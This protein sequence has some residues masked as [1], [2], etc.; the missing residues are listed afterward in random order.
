M[1]EL[2]L[3]IRSLGVEDRYLN[4]QSRLSIGSTAQEKQHCTEETKGEAIMEQFLASKHAQKTSFSSN[5]F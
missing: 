1:Q 4:I 3:P 2:L 5:E